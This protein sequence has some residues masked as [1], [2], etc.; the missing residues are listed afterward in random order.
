MKLI[1]I[2]E[3]GLV[4]DVISD[5][6]VSCLLVDKDCMEEPGD[7]YGIF[8]VANHEDDRD[9]FVAEVSDIPVIVNAQWVELYLEQK[10]EADKLWK[11]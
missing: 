5:E 10:R 8:E 4:Q 9:K 6:E 1:I 7:R 3:G 2:V 11:S